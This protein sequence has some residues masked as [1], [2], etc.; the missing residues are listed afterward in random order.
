[1]T[2]QGLAYILPVTDVESSLDNERYRDALNMLESHRIS[3]S[4]FAGNRD[5]AVFF[6]LYARTLHHLGE[7]RRALIKVKTAL[8][9]M[10]DSN[11]GS[12]YAAMK[13]TRGKILVR[14]GRLK[15]AVESFNESHVFYKRSNEYESML[16]PL[17]ALAHV[18]YI[19]GNLRRSCEVFELSLLYAEKH[20][21][22]KN[23]DIGKRN[24]A[25]VLVSMGEFRRAMT[26]LESIDSGAAADW[27]KANINRQRGIISLYRL[28]LVPARDHL[29]QA[30]RY[31]EHSGSVRDA[32]I[33]SEFLGLLCS[34][35]CQFQ[36]AR[37]LFKNI[38][39]G[40]E[41]TASAL[42]QTFRMLTDVYIAEGKFRKAS[43]T[44]KKAEDAINKI[45][46][47]IELGALYRAYG[48]IYTHKGETETARDYFKKSIDLL[49]EIGARY[50]LA[51]SYFTCGRSES[52]GHEERTSLLYTAHTLFDE[53]DVPKRV[54]QVDDAI[55]DLKSS[56][57]PNI[58]RSK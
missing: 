25:V 52:Y 37:E 44:A 10:R 55:L 7:D 28:E 51:L 36:K 15:D 12:S 46:E 13:M 49:K 24:L 31:F 32:N 57:I 56:A 34:Y 30:Q 11:D 41:P 38:L 23:I 17:D 33:C 22:R 14:L 4:C 2:K 21:T 6:H 45:G 39:E 1:M 8:R 54:E 29:T 26:I 3:C 47:R 50:E 48:Q 19:S 35:K 18:H 58:I 43:S 27:E 5:A 42:A 16:Y 9:L 40:T 53:M 20:K